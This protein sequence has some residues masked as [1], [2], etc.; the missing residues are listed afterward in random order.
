[1]GASAMNAPSGGVRAPIVGEIG[2]HAVGQGVAPGALLHAVGPVAGPGAFVPYDR[3]LRLW[4][5]MAER[6][7]DCPHGLLLSAVSTTTLEL[8]SRFTRDA[9]SVRSAVL[10]LADM[11]ADFSSDGRLLVHRADGDTRL[12]LEYSAHDDVFT[13][14]VE[15]SLGLVARLAGGPDAVVRASLRHAPFGAR[16]A[17]AA[18][19][20]EHIAFEATANAIVLRDDALDR[21]WG[22]HGALAALLRRTEGKAPSL[23]FDAASVVEAAVVRA[24]RR[25]DFSVLAVARQLGLSRRSLQRRANH[26]GVEVGALIQKARQAQA[27]ALLADGGLSL[28]EVAE[29][30]DYADERSFSRAFERWTGLTPARWRRRRR[31]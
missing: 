17:Y 19:L 3:V 20:G 26:V 4:A 10:I 31:R 21:A 28:R 2:R 11:Y 24:A 8:V 30:L 29:R 6:R 9:T 13:H 5:L 27:K 7:S 12:A 15:F 25:G 18:H 16:S 23:E 14:P 1:M 22:D